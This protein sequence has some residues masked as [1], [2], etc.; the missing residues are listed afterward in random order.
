MFRFGFSYVGLIYLLMLFIPNIIWTK[1]Q[2]QDYEQ[3]AQRE[4]K[5][6]Q[7]LERIGEVSV[8]CC[9]LIFSDFNIRLHFPWCIWL[10]VSFALML[11]Y[12]AYWIRYFR[13]EKRMS[14]FYRSICGIPV[15]GATLP[16]CAF[17]LLGVYGCN[18][19]LLVSTVILGIGH[20]GI[21][22]DHYK[23]IS[24]ASK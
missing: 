14:D 1:Y 23:E 20:I 13:S 19:F 2:P 7:M 18:L 24:G 4:N 11:L 17:L 21:H 6:L 15:A 16:V 5:V 3:Y 22:M 10:L 9:V 12:E 8:C